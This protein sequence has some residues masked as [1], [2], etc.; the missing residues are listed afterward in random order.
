MSDMSIKAVLGVIAFGAFAALGMYCDN[1]NE[2][3]DA[4]AR[5]IYKVSPEFVTVHNL[6]GASEFQT[7]SGGKYPTTTSYWTMADSDNWI[8][9]NG[10]RG[11]NL[12]GAVLYDFGRVNAP[13]EPMSL[14]EVTLLSAGFSGR[15]V[16]LQVRVPRFKNRPDNLDRCV[17]FGYDAATGELTV[18]DKHVAY[19]EREQPRLAQAPKP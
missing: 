7:Q 15:S 17:G 4:K 13:N 9:L 2:Q 11:T 8:L 16:E 3:N 18:G 6:R 10:P 19:L 1:V 5:E 12:C 14:A